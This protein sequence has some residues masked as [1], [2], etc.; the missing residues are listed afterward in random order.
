MIYYSHSKRIY[1]TSRED[2]EL[3]AIADHF[4]GIQIINPGSRQYREKWSS[5]DESEIM[6]ECF[7][8]IEKSEVV[9]FSEFRG[10]IGRGVWQELMRAF[11][12]GK[13]VVLLRNGQFYCVSP[14]DIEVLNE[15]K[16]WVEYAHV[17]AAH[18]C[19]N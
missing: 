4:R 5:L 6:A 17:V 15:G 10:K 19:P 13:S 11:R 18:P 1:G 8:L 3:R 9:V 12:L 16:S 14:S 2:V 7:R